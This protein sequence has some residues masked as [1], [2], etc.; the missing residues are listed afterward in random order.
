[1]PPIGCNRDAYH[2]VSGVGDGNNSLFT[3]ETSG[4]THRHYFDY[5]SVASTYSMRIGVKDEYNATA[6]GNLRFLLPM[7]LRMR[8]A[9]DL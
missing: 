5:E 4:I 3:L 7:F 1:M 6:E 9:M 2:L 8:M